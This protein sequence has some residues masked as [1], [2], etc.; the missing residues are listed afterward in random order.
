MTQTDTD[1][2]VIYEGPGEGA[3]TIMGASQANF[4]VVGPGADKEC[5]VL[6]NDPGAEYLA[7]QLGAEM[8]EAWREAITA[9]LGEI[10]IEATLG[11]SRHLDSVIFI[12]RAILQAH[13][14]YVAA[15]R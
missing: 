15:L 11:A 4:I 14:E 7:E 6:L 5:A 9:K 13:P 2:R 3:D 12:S 1:H 10:V 8:T